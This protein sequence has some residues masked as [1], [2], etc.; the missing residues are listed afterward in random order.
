[1]GTNNCLNGNNKYKIAISAHKTTQ[2]SLPILWSF[3]PSNF[4]GK[5]KDYESGFHYYG[6]RYYWCEVLTGWLSVDPMADKYPNIS[7]YA[8]C[9]WNPIKLVDPD[10]NEAS[11]HTDRHGNVLAVYNDGNLGVYAHSDSETQ[12]FKE[13]V[14]FSNNNT[15]LVGAT[16]HESSFKE[17]DKIDF[18]STSA[19]Q[20]MSC[21]E[22]WI[23]NANVGPID[24]IV[25]YGILARNG[26]MFD[27]K[28]YM[29]YG[30]QISNGTYISPRDL[31]N[32]AAGRIGKILGFS[33]TDILAKY[34]AFQLAGNNLGKLVSSFGDLYNQALK[35]PLTLEGQR[36]YGE[37]P[38][39]N[40][41]Q[42]LGYEG[43]NSIDDYRQRYS[44]IWKD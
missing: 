21:F 25:K 29:D 2:Q 38:I 5:E 13:G 31:G 20:W 39:S 3:F 9:A 18:H 23:S 42:R 33:K 24:G 27:P 4:N 28:S 36:T 1:M 7:P 41:F 8:Y 22:S 35:Y 11:T 44:D 19:E 37:D 34:G 12:A 16:L 14:S 32:Y 40:Y 17:G 26:Q 43:I 10:G 6:A 15:R 30:S